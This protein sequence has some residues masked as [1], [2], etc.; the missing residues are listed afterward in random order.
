[1]TSDSSGTY[2]LMTEANIHIIKLQDAAEAD[3]SQDQVQGINDK[4]WWVD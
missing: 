4:E 3:N 2:L 1:M